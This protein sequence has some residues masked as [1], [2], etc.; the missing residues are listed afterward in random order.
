MA[1]SLKLDLDLVADRP[2]LH[3]DVTAAPSDVSLGSLEWQTNAPL[4][5]ARPGA[6]LGRLSAVCLRA[7]PPHRV[8]I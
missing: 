8:R 3:G 7:L 5:P 6:L 1:Q 2:L 4:R